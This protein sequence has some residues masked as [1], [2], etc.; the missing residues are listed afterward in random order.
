MVPYHWVLLP[1]VENPFGSGWPITSPS[2]H[3]PGH[4]QVHT[5]PGYQ[6]IIK[7]EDEAVKIANE[8]GYT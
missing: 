8:V 3:N 2:P 7:D 5:V 6:G 4:G 1:P